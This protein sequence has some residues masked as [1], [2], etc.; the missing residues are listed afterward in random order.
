MIHLEISELLTTPIEDLLDKR[1]TDHIQTL[2]PHEQRDVEQAKDENDEIDFDR[3]MELIDDSGDAKAESESDQTAD[4]AIEN[5]DDSIISKEELEFAELVEL[6]G[7]LQDP[8]DEQKERFEGQ[9][10]EDA[11]V[12]EETDSDK[13]DL[14]NESADA[15][16]EFLEIEQEHGLITPE[17]ELDTELSDDLFLDNM[18]NQLYEEPDASAETVSETQFNDTAKSLSK[19]KIDFDELL[20]LLESAANTSSENHRER[21]EHRPQE[22]D[23]SKNDLLEMAYGAYEN[24]DY[25]HCISQLNHYISHY[26]LDVQAFHLLGNAYFRLQQYRD[27]TRAY[28]H[29]LRLEPNDQRALENLG[30]IY[31]NQGDFNRALLLWE[32]LLQQTPQRND[33]KKSIERAKKFLKDT[34]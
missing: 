14:E 13:A 7:G 17:G 8:S 18:E 20:N 24:K 33:L 30:V 31:A 11:T 34:V 21:T 15:F 19:K 27:A 9:I 1:G 5:P 12:L 25:N 6:G 23:I 26:P 16:E 2:Q 10:P 3:E 4:L 28:R 29:V 22:K 32:K